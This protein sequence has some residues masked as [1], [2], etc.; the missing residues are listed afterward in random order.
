MADPAHQA[1]PLH[2]RLQRSLRQLILDGQ[3]AAGRPLPASRAL[4]QSLAVSRDTVETAYSQL[5]AEGFITRRVGS[6]SQVSQQAR[7]LPARPT[8]ASL[9]AA[10]PLSQRGQAM[11]AAGG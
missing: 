2:A 7:R 3:L 4:A 10:P 9:A 6:G 1:L 8:A 11:L 5:H